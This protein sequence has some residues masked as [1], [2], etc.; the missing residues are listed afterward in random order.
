MA[1]GAK[2]LSGTSVEIFTSH[3]ADKRNPAMIVELS[4]IA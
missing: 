2:T 1:K 3:K 4:A